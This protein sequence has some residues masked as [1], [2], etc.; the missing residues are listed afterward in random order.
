[1]QTINFSPKLKKIKRW[2]KTS[3]RNCFLTTSN[4]HITENLGDNFMVIPSLNS[5]KEKSLPWIRHWQW[6]SLL[7]HLHFQISNCPR[8]SI[9]FHFRRTDSMSGSIPSAA[10]VHL[11][12]ANEFV[13]EA[14]D[15]GRKLKVMMEEL[16]SEA[17]CHM[18]ASTYVNVRF[19]LRWRTQ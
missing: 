5:G 15:N 11:S 17:S 16:F 19:S 10:A 6:H 4:G 12:D 1:M 18:I 8:F 9:L 2:R 13:A 3:L 14:I 7:L